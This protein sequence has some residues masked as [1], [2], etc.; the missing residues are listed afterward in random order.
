MK[1]TTYARKINVKELKNLF[2]EIKN[3]NNI[4]F[5][6]F[7]SKYDKLVLKITYS[8][9][10]NKNDAEDV[11]QLVF[12]KIYSMNKEKLPTKKMKLVGYILLP[13]T[14]H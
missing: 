10:K 2:A 11:M 6:K 9:L 8:I 14:K 13:E 7:Y 12:E 3:N 4:A 1:G 5:E